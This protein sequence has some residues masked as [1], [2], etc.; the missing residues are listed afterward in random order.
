M[1]QNCSLF[2][3]KVFTLCHLF[4]LTSFSVLHMFNGPPTLPFKKLRLKFSK[5]Y[6]FW[7]QIRLRSNLFV[8]V[9]NN[10]RTEIIFFMLWLKTLLELNGR[11]AAEG[12]WLARLGVDEDGVLVFSGG[13]SSNRKGRGRRDAGLH[14]DGGGGDLLGPAETAESSSHAR[15]RSK[16]SG[17]QGSRR[18]NGR[19][20]EGRQLGNAIWTWRDV[21]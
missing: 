14:L 19:V 21:L 12:G 8:V 9:A 2:V 20:G 11:V 7:I 17:P 3:Q 1:F 4:H 6:L 15:P 5:F 10:K 18:Q 13:S 16:T